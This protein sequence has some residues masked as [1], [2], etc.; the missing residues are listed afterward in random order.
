MAETIFKGGSI[1]TGYRVKIP[2]AI[3]DT[4]NLK[5]GTKVIM[6]FDAEKR[7]VIVEE[8]KKNGNNTNKGR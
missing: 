5:I 4:L 1:Q 6:R 3:I 8:E 7:F 2:K